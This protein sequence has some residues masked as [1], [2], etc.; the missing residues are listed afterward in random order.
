MTRD[1]YTS[2]VFWGQPVQGLDGGSHADVVGIF[3]EPLDA[4]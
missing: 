1:R 3:F 4:D 2:R